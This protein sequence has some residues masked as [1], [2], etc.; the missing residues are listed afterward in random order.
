MRKFFFK[1]LHCT[2]I[3]NFVFEI[4]YAGYMIFCVIK[5]EGH[6]GPLGANALAIPFEMMVTRRLYAIEFWIAFAGL[7]I[8]LA[9]T[10]PKELK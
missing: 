5:P 2:I 1:I 7:A 8:Y 3:G 10:C 6:S 9:L 4:F